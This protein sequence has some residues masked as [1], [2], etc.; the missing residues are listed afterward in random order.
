[1]E[2]NELSPRACVGSGERRS[3]PQ[4]EDTGFANVVEMC[5]NERNY[6]AISANIY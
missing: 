6:R 2:C 5:G 1:M 3:G 4:A